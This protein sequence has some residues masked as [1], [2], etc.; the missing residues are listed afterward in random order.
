MFP[1][2]RPTCGINLMQSSDKARKVTRRLAQIADRRNSRVLAFEPA[3]DRPVPGIAFLSPG[4]PFAS[5]AG[6]AS[7]K[8]GASFGNQCCSFSTCAIAASM[9]GSRT[10]MLSPSRKIA[11]SVPA[12][13]TGCRGKSAHCGNC[14]ASNR[15]TREMSTSTS[16]A[17]ILPEDMRTCAFDKFGCSLDEVG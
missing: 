11:L 15:L 12:E 13:R 9:R 5:G 10:A 6:I 8:Y 17:C 3:I 16:S 4:F 7:G 14:A 1:R 2:E